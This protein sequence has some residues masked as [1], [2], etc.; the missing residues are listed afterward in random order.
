MAM[1][2]GA[3]AYQPGVG[4]VTGFSQG[5]SPIHAA[6]AQQ[7][8]QGGGFLHAALA[9]ALGFAHAVS[10]H[11][12]GD[13]S[14]PAGTPLHN[15]GPYHFEDHPENNPGHVPGQPQVYGQGPAWTGAAMPSGPTRQ[16]AYRAY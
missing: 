15:F 3:S 16:R 6:L 13:G 1:P 14:T 11:L 9:H 2:Q 10:S 7:A 4:G 5:G 12:A 8:P